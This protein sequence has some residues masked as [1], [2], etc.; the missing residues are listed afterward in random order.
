[1]ISYIFFAPT[2][3]RVVVLPT[4]FFKEI[5]QGVGERKKRNSS[6]I[7]NCTVDYGFYLGI[8]I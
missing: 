2:P 6:K 3:S 5:H 1:M 7:R 4:E 8:P